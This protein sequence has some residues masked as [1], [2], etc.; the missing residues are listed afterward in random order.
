M[1]EQAAEVRVVPGA[2][3]WRP[4]QLRSQRGVAEEPVQQRAVLAVVHLSR[5]MLEKAVELV[6]VA[7]GGRE[8]PRRVDPVAI[9][10]AGDRSHLEDELVAEP[11]DGSRRAHKVSPVESPGARAS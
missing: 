11:L 7:V 6:Q 5:E 1:L 10:R 2:R 3:A 4:P 8:E 9:V